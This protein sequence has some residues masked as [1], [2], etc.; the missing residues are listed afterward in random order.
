ME[1]PN[2]NK[3]TEATE[4]LTREGRP[5]FIPRFNETEPEPLYSSEEWAAFNSAIENFARVLTE[6]FT[7]LIDIVTETVKTL[8]EQLKPFLAYTAST[9]EQIINLYPNKHVI[10][11][12][13]H[14]K[15]RTKK[16]NINRILKWYK[17]QN[18]TPSKKRRSRGYIYYTERDGRKYAVYVYR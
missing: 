18:K 8:M 15:G 9:I 2:G 17:E 5:A 6:T 11:L 16:K 10:Y 3:I 1:T 12:A 4:I 7:P 14:G 13:T